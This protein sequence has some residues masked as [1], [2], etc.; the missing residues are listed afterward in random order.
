MKYPLQRTLS[1]LLP[2]SVTFVAIASQL[3]IAAVSDPNADN[4]VDFGLQIRPILAEHCFHCHGP[5]APHREANLRLDDEESAKSTDGRTNGL[6]AIAPSDLGMSELWNRIYSTDPDTVMPPPSARKVLTDGQK[7]LLK[8]WIESG[9][10]WGT[11]WSLA[12]LTAPKLPMTPS[13]PWAKTPIDAWVLKGLEQNH[14]Q[15]SSPADDY[16]LAR[17]LYLDLIGLPPSPSR[18]KQFVE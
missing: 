12:P 8:R 7:E 15:P 18:L 1:H 11:H 14:L 10:T 13:S 5:D 9:A 3:A 2:A 16:T 17:R 4:G 6:A